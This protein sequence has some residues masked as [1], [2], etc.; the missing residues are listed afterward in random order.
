MKAFGT[1]NEDS[2]DGSDFCSD[3]QVGYHP[4]DALKNITNAE[5]SEYAEHTTTVLSRVMILHP[6]ATGLAF[7][8]FLLALGS[9]M[10]GSVLASLMAILTFL[11]TLCVLICDFVLFGIIKSNINNADAFEFTNE[12]G[13]SS[14]GESHAYFSVGMWTTLISAICSLIASVVVVLACCSKRLKKRRHDRKIAHDHESSVSPHAHTHKR[15][16]WM[17][18]K[19]NRV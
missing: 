17:F 16:K 11:T 13:S 12:E 3:K 14:Q 8:S 9:G 15:R 6:I 5:F 19:R 1:D 18:W 4:V 10:L 2:R 7:I